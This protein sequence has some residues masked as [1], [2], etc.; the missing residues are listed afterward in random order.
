VKLSTGFTINQKGKRK[1]NT[2][3]N[4]TK[5]IVIALALLMICGTLMEMLVQPTQAQLA[6][7]QPTSGPIPAGATADFT[8][9]TTPYLSVRP[10]PIGINQ[11]LLVNIW[12]LPAPHPA[13]L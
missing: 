12:I 9:A 1:M 3:K 11:Q 7:T 4:M 13:R 5:V 6:A 2:Q 8:V 10:N